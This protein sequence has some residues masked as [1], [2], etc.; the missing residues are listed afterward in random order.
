MP[1]VL[2][3][4]IFLMTVAADLNGKWKGSFQIP[5]GTNVQATYTFK[6]E[7]DKFTGIAE[8]AGADPLTIENGKISGNDFSFT[9]NLGGADFMHKGKIYTDS[10]SMDIDFGGTNVHTTLTRVKE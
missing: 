9:I 7:G 4:F 2:T 6:V 5:D 8:A 10:C 3:C 1:A